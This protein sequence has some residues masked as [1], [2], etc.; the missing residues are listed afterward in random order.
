MVY[1]L[2]HKGLLWGCRVVGVFEILL[3]APEMLRQ[4]Q[5][6]PYLHQ[7]L[8]LKKNLKSMASYLRGWAALI[9]QIPLFVFKSDK[10]GLV[11]F[12]RLLQNTCIL[13]QLP[14]LIPPHSLYQFRYYWGHYEY[15]L[16][17]GGQRGQLKLKLKL[18]LDRIT[19][20]NCLLAEQVLNSQ[21]TLALRHREQ[22]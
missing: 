21:W 1:G 17:L 18:H 13:K 8:N 10:T 12:F 7:C 11:F 14:S 6:W 19:E 15:L 9:C 2:G 5:Q 16:A 20:I 22:T 3:T 4:A